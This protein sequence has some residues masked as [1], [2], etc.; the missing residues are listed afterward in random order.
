MVAAQRWVNSLPTQ[1]GA[2]P[3][4]GNRFVTLALRLWS[5][6]FLWPSVAWLYSASLEKLYQGLSDGSETSHP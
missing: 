4:V 1:F 6:L 2:V 5:S 3:R